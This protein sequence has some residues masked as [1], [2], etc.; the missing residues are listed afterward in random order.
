MRNDLEIMVL[1]SSLFLLAFV[2]LAR[3]VL[4]GPKAAAILRSNPCARQCETICNAGREQ[5]LSRVDFSVATDRS[6]C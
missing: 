4:F 2:Y 1:S 5:E 6:V 3:N